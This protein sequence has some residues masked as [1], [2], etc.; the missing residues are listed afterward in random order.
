MFY[1][2]EWRV[3]FE[4]GRCLQYC[5]WSLSSWL[6]QGYLISAQ[7]NTY[8][9]PETYI[10]LPNTFSEAHTFYYR[11]TRNSN[12]GF[13][14]SGAIPE[15]FLEQRGEKPYVSSKSLNLYKWSE[16][17]F[18]QGTVIY[19]CKWKRK[20]RKELSMCLHKI[21]MCSLSW[22]YDKSVALIF[23]QFQVFLFSYQLPYFT[24][25]FL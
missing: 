25:E 1:L 17:T 3:W 12:L 13:S 9:V 11:L 6:E 22:E 14:N 18:V 21:K 23:H 8:N 7:P 15:I 24:Q 20:Y 16:R 10:H 5:N 2:E 4:Y 19:T